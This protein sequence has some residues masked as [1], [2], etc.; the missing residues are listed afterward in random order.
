MK[1]SL[2]TIV[3]LLLSVA[4]MGQSLKQNFDFGWEFAETDVNLTETAEWQAV[5]LPHDWDHHHAP[6]I[7]GASGN[8]GGYYPGGIGWYRKSFA[9]PQIVD[10]QRVVLH[11]EGVYH[12]C[13]VYLNGQLVGT[14]AYGFTPFKIDIT[15]CLEAACC[16]TSAC[17][18]E[19]KTPS[20]AAENLNTL[21]IRVDNSIQP[22]CRW[23]SGSGIIR[24]TW[25]EVYE[26]EDIADPDLFDD[27]QKLFIRTVGLEGISADGRTAKKATVLITYGA[28]PSATAKAAAERS[29]APAD[30]PPPAT[31]QSASEITKSSGESTSAP[32]F[33]ELRTFTD[34]ELWSPE[35]PALYDI[36]V[37]KLTVKHG[38]RTFSFSARDGFLLNGQP[39][40]IN[41]ACVHHD[42]GVL[43]AMA[44]DAAEIRKV[45]LM[46]QAGFNLIRTSHNPTTRA[47][48]DACD[49]LGMMVID[50][51][52][53]GWY[54]AKK[55]GDH[56]LD[57]D[58]CYREDFAAL[59]LRDRN[60]PSVICWSIGNEVMERKDIRIV[61]TARK[62]KKE[63]LRW[64]DTRP[65][66]EAI[67]T[68]DDDWEIFDPHLEVLD[69]VGYNYLINKHADDHQRCPERVFWQTESF[70][71]DAFEN[72][73]LV[74]EYPYLLGDIVWTGLDYLGES[75]IGQYYYEGEPDGEHW[76]GT[77]FPFHGAYCGDVDITGWRKA[78][79]HYRDLLY[80]VADGDCSR[81]HLA[82]REPVGY[83]SGSI[84]E[85]SWS[86]WPTWES[87]NFPGWEG[88]GIEAE[89]CTKAPAVRLYLNGKVVAEQAVGRDTEY[90][91]VVTLPYQ[92]GTLRAVAL[93]KDGK[94]CA[95]STLVTSGPASSILLLP[96][97]KTVKADGEDLAYIQ[98]QVVDRK[99]NPVPD[100]SIPVTVTVSG[101]GTFLAAGS[102]NFKDLEAL[103][104]NK[105]TT[106]NG[107][108]VI[109][110]RSSREKGTI[111]VRAE[112]A[113]GKSKTIKI[114]SL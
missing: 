63:I 48:M 24:H 71:R 27:P 64:D 83:K 26:P 82:V 47:F 12:R 7:D 93:D 10:G 19:S 29:K 94:E 22:G 86:T 78:V 91:A 70:P 57:I 58:S 81:I 9:T 40:I 68:W 90:M 100:A 25:L 5:D 105:V 37:G 2:L 16:H 36:S 56:A 4:A 21:A 76:E 52:Y 32:T 17:S 97:Q 59:V 89:I 33:S 1:H 49:S 107:R 44:F 75:G 101:A 13:S 28:G 55:P 39:T 66:T 92:P 50:E 54:E 6:S 11:F 96:E 110:V 43:G 114:K 51:M 99:G 103:S 67:C 65:V 62:F 53:D 87:W 30:V 104:S 77:H 23:Y 38:F 95:S 15:Q 73:A 88:R 34:V 45:R 98:V 109:V 84:S 35:H 112:S 72:W 3:S 41:G 106:W 80:N 20:C 102:A 46:K 18:G 79:S 61:H 85:T 113:F 69:I 42:D 60:H 111:T 8:D 74:T 14:H 31:A 108:A